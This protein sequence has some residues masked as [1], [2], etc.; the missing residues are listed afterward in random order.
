[1]RA[2]PYK[3]LPRAYVTCLQD[4]AIPPALQRRMLE[5]A[6]C[7]PVIEIDTDHS[8]VV[9]RTEETV[10]VLDGLARCYEPAGA[11]AD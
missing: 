10:A 11:R 1:M 3:R 7:D 4:R 9:S 6:G 5:A 8:P 2:R